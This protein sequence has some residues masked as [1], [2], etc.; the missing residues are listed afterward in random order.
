[1]LDKL[2]EILNLKSEF[3]KNVLTLVTG[4]TIAQAIP[5]A[6]SPILTR[7]YTPEDFGVLA[8]FISITTI[9]GTIA[10]GRY[11]LA[12]VLPKRDNNA[13]ELTALSII[14]T[15][16][17]SLLLVI[18]VILFHDSLLSYLNN[19][20]FSFWLYLIPLSVLLFSLFNILN[21]YH[22]R[23]KEY[24]TITKARMS[25]SV[26]MALIQTLVGLL[27]RVGGGLIG[28]SIVSY[29]A[30]NYVM[31]RNRIG[32]HIFGEI[33]ASS[34]L[35]QGKRYINFPKYSLFGS[36]ANILSIHV[37]SIFITTVYSA[38]ILGFYSLVYRVLAMPLTL[39]GNSL[40]QVYLQEAVE[41]KNK[42]GITI[43]TFRSTL[44]KLVA[45]TIPIF[46]I[47][48]LFIDDLFAFIFGNEWQ[49]AGVYAKILLPLFFIRFIVSPLTVTCSI[50]EKQKIALIWQAFF[51][52]N[53]L[54]VF[55][56]SYLLE[57]SFTDFLTAFNW[58]S[59]LQYLFILAIII[60]LAR[61]GKLIK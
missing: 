55:L 9:L 19:D 7:I 13:L 41:E 31:L 43:V 53:I 57:I 49:I 28:G 8:L 26:V 17:F 16:G 44:I 50:F 27:F 18:L 58:F 33:Q 60:K 52:V 20:R 21:Y 34:L 32:K 59:F 14:I 6:I 40:G 22:T 23:K 56:I 37:I 38:T 4:T 2:K 39:I 51:L 42:T 45:I 35:Q 48:Y 1:M 10:N 30:G 54:L 5:I 11:E 47:L 3:S 61:D 46:G 12:I 36:L 24:K 29:I 25:R 15:M